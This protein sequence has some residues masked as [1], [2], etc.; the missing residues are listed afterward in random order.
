MSFRLVRNLSLLFSILCI[1]IIS[2]GF[3]TSGNDRIRNIVTPKQS[4]EEFCLLKEPF[5]SFDLFFRHFFK[6]L[7]LPILTVISGDNMNIPGAHPAD[8]LS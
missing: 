4:F 2:E 7:H 3:P 8:R 6:N 1:H 5:L